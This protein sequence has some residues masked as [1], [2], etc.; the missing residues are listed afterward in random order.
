MRKNRFKI[1]HKL[2]I[3]GHTIT[4]RFVDDLRDLTGCDGIVKYRQNEIVIQTDCKGIRKT[5][6]QIEE[7]FLHELTHK[8][9]AEAGYEELAENEKFVKLF[10]KL[11][12]QALTSMEYSEGEDEIRLDKLNIL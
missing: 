3:F 7:V 12:H 9:L 11:L 2:E 6:G 5:E 10:S 8:I 1:P 4:I